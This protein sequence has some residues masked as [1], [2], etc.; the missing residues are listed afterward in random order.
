[1]PRHVEVVWDPRPESADPR[2][3]GLRGRAVPCRRWRVLISVLM[4]GVLACSRD[5]GPAVIGVSIL[6]GRPSVADVAQEVLDSSPGAPPLIQI[7]VDS[8][9]PIPAGDSTSALASAVMIAE[10][11]VALPGLVGV[12]GHAGSRDAL[13]AAPTYNRSG[14][15]LIVPTATSMLLA[16]S[17]EWTFM[18]A[19]SDSI[20]GELIGRFA[21]EQLG[22]RNVTLF[23]VT[24]EYG[25][26]L[27]LGA[28]RALRARGINILDEVPMS[29][30]V[31]CHGGSKPDESARTLNAH[32]LLLRGTPD[33]IV[34]ATSTAESSCILAALQTHPGL[35]YLAGD[36]TLASA[37]LMATGGQAVDSLYIVA[38]WYP[39][40]ASAESRDFVRRFERTVG[41]PPN[42]G[43]AMI[44]DGIM[45]LAA[46]VRS[47]GTDRDAIRDFLLSLGHDRP[48][49]TG[50]TG[51]IVFPA[52]GAGLMVT[53][54]QRGAWVPVNLP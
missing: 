7:V 3:A 6:L 8:G 2:L 23:Y 20:E 17:G 37:D 47:V 13:I 26:G 24:D 35:R 5:R 19:P 9:R 40:R 12:V 54:M 41:R 45:T 34:L 33:L 22:A 52:S 25:T 36:G 46:A 31:Q 10:R 21:D 11:M 15:P 1:M 28:A 43:D 30:D 53:R 50:V 44:Y 38:F 16:E 14:I 49:L 42:P 51:P 27:R 48:A 29:H 39:G 32:Q 4:A 18:L